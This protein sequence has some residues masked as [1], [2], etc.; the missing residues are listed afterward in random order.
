MGLSWKF[1]EFSFILFDNEYLLG[2]FVLFIDANFVEEIF[3]WEELFDFS[4]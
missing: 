2:L 3:L 4:S 1:E